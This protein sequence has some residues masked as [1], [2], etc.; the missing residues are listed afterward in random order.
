MRITNRMTIDNA[1]QHISESREKSS[2]LTKQISTGKQFQNA[3]EDP[4]RASL[5]LSLR[6]NLRTLDSYVDT[7]DSTKDWMSATDSA[8]DRLETLATRATTL[9]LRGLNDTI[10]GSESATTL[11]T[12]MQTLAQQAV[13]IGNTSH[14]NQFIFAGY[15]IST[16]PFALEDATPASTS[17]FTN[18]SGNTVSHQVAT[19][20]GDT[21][22]IQ[23]ILGPDQSVTLNVT[24][25]PSIQDFIQNLVNASEALTKDPAVTDPYNPTSLQTVLTAL[26][27]SLSTINQSRT[28]NGAR[29]RQVESAAD[30]LDQ[31]KLETKGLLSKKEDVNV[32]EAIVLLTGE[33]TTFDAVLEVSQRAISALSLFDYIQ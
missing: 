21:N 8:L 25:K 13:E 32:A 28:S 15:K 24:G 33:K 17:T 16:K 14:N 3:S 5:S 22:S 18:Y 6:S 20:Y 7:T 4:V 11:G 9:V 31:I 26:Q 27:S 23:R 12:E 30:Y 1:I 10:S 29:L 2:K 19:Y